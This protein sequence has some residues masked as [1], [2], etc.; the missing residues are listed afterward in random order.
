[1]KKGGAEANDPFPYDAIVFDV[2]ETILPNLCGVGKLEQ[3]LEDIKKKEY[4]Y[5]SKEG[6]P[7]TFTL[8]D[9]K[10]LVKLL[11]D[12]KNKGI[13]LF[14]ATRCMSTLHINHPRIQPNTDSKNDLHMEL[15]KLHSLF[16]NNETDLRM[17]EA[18][19]SVLISNLAQGSAKWA[20]YKAYFFERSKKN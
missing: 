12:I 4:S 3:L 18:D 9:I 11:T 8:D 10:K 16:R 6:Q 2:D 20:K 14:I 5:T 15:I 7:L 13:P 17:L 19:G 1:M